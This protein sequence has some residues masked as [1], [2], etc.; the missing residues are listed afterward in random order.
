MSD[1]TNSLE[2]TAMGYASRGW[3]VVP[4]HHVKPDGS[5]SCGQ[6]DEGHAIGK[7]PRLAGWQNGDR[8][9]PAAV[10][11]IWRQWP[12]ANV[13]LATGER[14]GFFVLDVDPD[15]G[16]D[17]SVD[18]LV[19]KH[20]P[21]PQTYS[22][23]T[24]SGGAHY[25]F[26]MPD[27]PVSNSKG[28]L[29][30][31][32]DVRGTGGQVVSPPS[33]TD[34][35]DYVVLSD[36]AIKAAPE[37]LLDYI[38]REEPKPI[39]P[40]SNERGDVELAGYVQAIL[41]REVDQALEGAG[42]RNNALN[43]AC[44]SVAT[45]IP[46]GVIDEEYV[47]DVFTEAGLA[48]GLGVIEVR[49]TVAS[50]IKGG[51]SKPRSPWPPPMA[52]AADLGFEFVGGGTGYG[53][54]Q[55]RK[56][57]DVGNGYRMLD[58]YGRVMKWVPERGKWAVYRDGRW[59]YSNEA[60]RGLVHRMLA[61]AVATE[62]LLYSDM[63]QTTE[64]KN[65]KQTTKPSMRADFEV[66][67]EKQLMSTRVDAALK[68]AQAVDKMRCSAAD[69]DSKPMLLNCPNG[70]VELPENP[71]DV[72]VLREHRPEDLITQMAAVPYDPDAKALGWEA[73]LLE[74]MPDDADRDLLHR[75]AGYS[76]T[77]KTSEQCM[78]VHH[79]SG[80]NGKSQFALAVSITLGDMAQTTPRE[81]FM[82]HA[83][84][85]H[86]TDVARMVAKRFLTTIEPATGKGLN[87]ELVKQLTGNDTMAARFMRSDFFEFRPT[88][89]IHYFT[90]HLPSMSAD[91]AMWR[92]IRLFRWQVTIPVERRVADL[93]EIMARDEG[94]GILAW[95]VRG[96]AKWA[97]EGL[98]VDEAMQERV[99][100]WASDED[101]MQVWIDE[102][103]TKAP[104]HFEPVSVL[105]NRWAEWCRLMGTHPSTAEIF[106]RRLGEKGFK[107]TRKS[108]EGRQVR[109]FLGL[110]PKRIAHT[111]GWLSDP[112]S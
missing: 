90:N 63:Q 74:V 23:M 29:P 91:T 71:G 16:G 68:E 49:K 50:A 34:R 38:R 82:K 26:L 40:G 48:V 98:R 62:G 39:T 83:G 46:H 72:A 9:D 55:T 31:G 59:T 13:G 87:E 88:G 67:I 45:M 102:E 12:K 35:G 1:G 84:D 69:F 81:T 110:M 24:G 60:A 33:R 92:R 7:H 54:I 28:R 4:L 85:R 101:E 15:K 5:C 42:G 86:P 73:F 106:G 96:C 6:N 25:Y 10:Q 79:G 103:M 37:W 94:P 75:V 89:K 53:A 30:A 77:G 2:T 99:N 11:R 41:D 104:E 107:R 80:A 17:A 112:E 65:G 51:K 100:E 32:L 78:F 111:A 64:D 52:A 36:G 108:I 70:T 19:Q 61:K 18:K 47:R 14:S 27:F 22:V 76:M 105:Y 93:G 57:N 8:P 44:F 56:W 20:G 21:L 43:E 66:W 58:H 97:A 109:G 95:L 3:H